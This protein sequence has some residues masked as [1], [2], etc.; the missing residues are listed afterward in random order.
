MVSSQ[1]ELVVLES[2]DKTHKITQKNHKTQNVPRTTKN[3]TK[4]QNVKKN[5]KIQNHDKN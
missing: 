5:S 2:V 3:N 4:S 1:Q